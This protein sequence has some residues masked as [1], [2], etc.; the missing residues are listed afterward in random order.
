MTGRAGP[1][2]YLQRLAVDPDAQ[3]CGIGSALVAD[4]LRWLKRWGA[5]EVLVNTQEDNG[6]AVALYEHLGFRREAE[7]LAVLQRPLAGPTA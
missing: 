5:R 3:R 2:G 4:A 6:G 1:R 7:G